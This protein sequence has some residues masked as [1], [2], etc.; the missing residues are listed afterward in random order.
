MPSPLVLGVVGVLLGAAAAL[1]AALLWARGRLR[2]ERATAEGRVAVAEA[3]ARE[4]ETRAA[5]VLAAQKEAVEAARRELEGSFRGL[6]AQ[7]LEG[8]NRRFLDQAARE[9]ALARET[10][11]GDLERHK[12][13]LRAL[14]EPLGQTLSRL[15][16]RTG[17]LEKARE[18]AY[19]GLREGLES[20]TRVAATLQEKTTSLATALRG[21]EAKGRWG[22]LALRNVVEL[23]GMTEYCDFTVQETVAGGRRPD[24]IVRL[25][26]ERLI[27]VDAKAPLAGYLAAQE[28][29]TPEV[30]EEHLIRH[31]RDL[32]QHVRALSARGYA[33]DLEG[34]VDLVVMF[35]PGDPFLAAGMAHDADLLEDALRARILVCTP[36]TLVALLRTVA[37]YWQQRSLAENAERI[38]EVARELYERAALFGEHLDGVGKGLQ[39]AI[40]A[41]NQTVGSFETRLKPMSRRLE[42][43][44][45][46]EQARRAVATPRWIEEAPREIQEPM[47]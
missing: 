35:L 43:F 26:G 5:E 38:A 15:E 37:I 27:A 33:A 17:E 34:N 12:S 3:V 31:A 13:D 39:E 18:S 9:L 28:A 30:R 21:S 1:A 29:A 2:A 32:R 47:L 7:A 4:R 36:T 25:P 41:Y 45:V 40:K 6:A 20:L 44:K 23:A 14:L 24:M 11:K 22:E 42:D 10:G 19:G 8:N 16:T 46:T